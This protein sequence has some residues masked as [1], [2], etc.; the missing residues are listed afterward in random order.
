MSFG[1]NPSVSGR[2]QGGLPSETSKSG[3]FEGGQSTDRAGG[4]VS[5]VSSPWL[6]AQMCRFKFSPERRPWSFEHISPHD[7]GITYGLSTSICLPTTKHRTTKWVILILTLSKIKISLL[8]TFTALA[9]YVLAVGQITPRIFLLG[10][11]IFILASGSC[12]LNQYQEREIDR[13]MARTRS[14][15]LPSGRLEASVALRIALSLLFVASLML[16]YGT[17]VLAMVLGLLAIFWYNGLYTYLK[18]KTAFAVLPGALIG[19]IPPLLGWVSGGGYLFDPRIWGIAFFLFIWQVPHFWLLSLE[20]AKDYESAGLPS[21][22]K[23]FSPSQ[24]KRILFIWFLST[25]ATCLLIPLFG[26]GNLIPVR[27]FL[28]GVTCL[29][30]LERSTFF[31]IPFFGEGLEKGI[32]KPQSLCLSGRI[33]PIHR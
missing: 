21:I 25:G 32:Y 6:I 18:R 4:T 13:L 9:G 22:T 29:A 19:M 15:P 5:R 27:I 8:V 12:A 1:R 10:G 11:A 23:I 17:N 24:I 31:Q 7:R 26:F 33:L 30:R 3:S 28:L 2:D 14:R 16:F 20:V